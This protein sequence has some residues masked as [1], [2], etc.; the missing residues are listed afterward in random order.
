VIISI[1]LTYTLHL[2]P[3]RQLKQRRLRWAEHVTHTVRK[4]WYTVKSF[5]IKT[6]NLSSNFIAQEMHTKIWF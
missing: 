2:I 6:T 3:L 5:V 1:G 4:Y